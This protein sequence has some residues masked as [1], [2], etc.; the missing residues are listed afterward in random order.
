MKKCEYCGKEISYY[1][2]YCSD[3]CQNKTNKFYDLRDNYGKLF[4]FLDTIFVFLIPIGVFLGTLVGGLGDGM[5]VTGFVGLGFMLLFL[6]FPTESMIKK[7]KIMKAKKM[8]RIF[9]L[10]LIAIGII[11]AIIMFA[12]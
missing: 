9:G 1:D 7:H 8:C 6:P 2:M 3:E 10:V 5:I 11:G 4:T 12:I